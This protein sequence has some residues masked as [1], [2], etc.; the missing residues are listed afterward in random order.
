MDNPPL[1]R[2][3]AVAAFALCAL[4]TMGSE[5]QR[6]PGSG[7][8][9]GPEAWYAGVPAFT[10][11][12]GLPY[13]RRGVQTHQFC[14]YDRAG[15]NYD[16]DYFPICAD[17][18]GECVFFDAYGPGCLYRLQ[19]N[20]WNGDVK[21]INIRFYFDDEPKARIDMD[22][23]TFFSTNN[24][25]RIF[26]APLAHVAHGYRLLY[27][28]FFFAKRLRVALSR[29]PIGPAPGWDKLPWEGHYKQHPARRNH[30]YQFTYHTFTENPGLSS[31]THPPD[32]APVIAMWN[33]TNMASP[34]Q[35]VAG[36]VTDTVE[37][38]LPAGADAKALQLKKPGAIT[39]MRLSLA[40]ED[41]AALF[42]TWLTIQFDGDRKPQVEAPLGCM[43]GAYRTT[44]AQRIT[45]RFIGTQGSEMYCYLPMPF[46]KS[47]TV[48]FS[49]RGTRP[50]KGIRAEIV[51]LPAS[52]LSYPKNDC[53]YFHVVYH[54]EAPRTEG[55]DYQY[56]STRGS[57]H[58]VGHFVY[59]W[60]TSM[61]ENERTYFDDSQTPSIEGD[62]YEDDHNQGWGLHVLRHAI[63]GSVA[64]HG[65]A[66]SVWRFFLPDL[67]V[68]QS[69]VR[70]G[71]QVYGPNSP[72]GHEGMY[73]PGREESVSFLYLCDKEA[74]ALTDELDVGSAASE[75]RHSYQVLGSRETRQGNWWYDGEMNNVLFRT[76][77]IADDGV[78]TDKGSEFTV[79]IDRRNNG[80]RLRR[81]TDKENN[82]QLARV[83]IDDVLVR[84]RPWYNVDFERTFRN[85]RWLDTDFEVPAAYTR[86][87]A[88]IRVR[89]ELQSSKTGRWD[90]S[91]YWVY[92]YR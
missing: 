52:A 18:S 39:A 43:F 87:K 92:S 1:R 8:T 65:G 91:H 79:K 6:A 17:A 44:P 47:A 36:A 80:V 83:Y 86:G 66:G 53:G 67:Y 45:S 60:D 23:T 75:K 81:R 90:E 74:L 10:A 61:E 64:S 51:H 76:P 35:P 24:P 63:Y 62:G 78:S 4:V 56:L 71:H 19:M 26:Q 20:I 55:H 59:R 16:A 21:G 68:F 46:W 69:M 30:W 34:P 89:I 54:R 28:P 9:P 3:L 32:M 13:L 38:A 85:I 11:L 40:P 31:W 82:Q 25:L 88:K 58:V 33:P 7:T 2:L 37:L 57:G 42:D 14:S 22:V 27:H 48:S 5:T 72:R 29:E 41:E 73:Q 84:E 70:Q 15:D 77:A 49:N 50:L 12:E